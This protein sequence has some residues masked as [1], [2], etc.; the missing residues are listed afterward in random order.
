MKSYQENIRYTDLFHNPEE[1]DGWL[2]TSRSKH[3][4]FLEKHS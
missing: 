1:I 4:G 2:N 3:A